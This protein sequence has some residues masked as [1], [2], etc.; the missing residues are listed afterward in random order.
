[1]WVWQ[2]TLDSSEVFSP[3]LG[4]PFLH[5]S[6]LH[7]RVYEDHSGI[8]L[9]LIHWSLV[10][11]P[12]LPVLERHREGVHLFGSSVLL[13]LRPLFLFLPTILFFGSLCSSRGI[14]FSTL[15][16]CLSFSLQLLLSPSGESKRVFQVGCSE[17]DSWND[18]NESKGMAWDWILGCRFRRC[19]ASVWL[20]SSKLTNLILW[21]STLGLFFKQQ[22]SVF[23]PIAYLLWGIV[24]D[25]EI[26][27]PL[28]V[29]S[30]RFCFC[31]D[32]RGDEE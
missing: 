7:R 3:S 28:P 29:W 20:P 16:F 21:R 2:W 32:E 9:F 23:H 17:N 18:S 27:Y 24:H 15:H 8:D 11:F 31:T 26:Q 1:M 19:L 25:V 4:D 5:L 13:S 22:S 14:Q 6:F 30:S 10:L 12:S